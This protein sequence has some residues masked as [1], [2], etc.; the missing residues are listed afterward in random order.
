MA[1]YNSTQFTKNAMRPTHGERTNQQTM[2]ATVALTTALV[3]ADTINMLRLPPYARVIGAVVSADQLDTNGTPTLALTVGDLGVGVAG[4]S[5]YVAPNAA[6]YFTATT[7]G[8][9]AGGVATDSNTNQIMR[10]QGYNFWNN[11]PA[12]C[13]VQVTVT[14]A[15]AT[16]QAGNIYLSIEYF[17]D[18]PASVLNQ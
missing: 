5:N 17:V 7:V 9:A 6:R 15:A 16:F 10:G 11:Q 2:Q 12:P 18:E 14:T 4:G 3:A 8:R 1:I 13:T